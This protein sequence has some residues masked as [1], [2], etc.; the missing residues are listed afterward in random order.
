[1]RRIPRWGETSADGRLLR[2]TAGRKN[3]GT[4]GKRNSNGIT[5]KHWNRCS[6]GTG[7]NLS[8]LAA[9]ALLSFQDATAGCS[10]SSSVRVE[11]F[12]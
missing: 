9:T 11:P 5:D 10:S 2:V 3:R 4:E 8:A 7:A 12:R 6:D 1:M